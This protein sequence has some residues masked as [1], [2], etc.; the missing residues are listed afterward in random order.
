[1]SFQKPPSKWNAN[2]VDWSDPDLK[3]LLDRS[4]GWT[5][6]NRSGFEAQRVE[7]HIGWGAS[8]GRP[9]LLV[10]ERGQA[11]VLETQFPI[12]KDE[13]LR[14]DRHTATGLRSVW[15]VVAD[16]RKGTRTDDEENNIYVHWVH[17]Q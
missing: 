1:M 14:I 2:Q 17:T 7:V 10:W 12:A 8:G 3:A 5:L 4:E 16:G 13:K 11:L 15:G 9:A 6:D